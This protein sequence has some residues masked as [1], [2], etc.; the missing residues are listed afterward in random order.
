MLLEGLVYLIAQIM[1]DIYRQPGII[2]DSVFPGDLLKSIE[3]GI[4][5]VSV[6]PANN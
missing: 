1:E 4:R 6:S 2:S 5:D 3:Q